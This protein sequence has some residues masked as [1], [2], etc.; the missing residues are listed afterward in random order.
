MNCALWALARRVLFMLPP[1]AAHQVTLKSLHYLDKLKLLPS[2][3]D[4]D[5]EETVLL[6]GLKFKN[7][8]GLA[9][10]FDKY[11]HTIEPLFKL[12]F[13]FVEIG[14]I[15]LKPQ[16]GNPKPRIFRLPKHQAIINRMG[17]NNPGVDYIEKQLS[18]I[19]PSGILGANLAKNRDTPPEKAALEYE[20]LLTRLYPYLDY[21]TINLSCPNTPDYKAMRHSSHLDDIMAHLHEKAKALE[22]CFGKKV[23]L[24]YKISPDLNQEQIQ[25]IADSANT[26]HIDGLIAGNTSTQ[27]FATQDTQ[28]A[29]QVGGLSGTPLFETSTQV[30]GHFKQYLNPKITLIGC[31]GIA[32]QHDAEIKRQ[33]GADLIQLYT[34]LIYQGPS[35]IR[36]LTKLQ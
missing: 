5:T 18:K 6:M 17:L 7:R 32:C 9:A 2:I 4:H 12:G 16:A 28:N 26:H 11:A 31:G 19:N 29:N 1:E 15:T 25:H 21:A 24:V 8:I 33:A 13:G 3:S 14:G 23:P 30:L 20:A 34:G 27:R 10:G 36:Q 35:L 22:D